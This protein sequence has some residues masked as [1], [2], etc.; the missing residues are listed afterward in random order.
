MTEIVLKEAK[1]K[2]TRE[3]KILATVAGVWFTVASLI[4]VLGAV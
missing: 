1:V 4:A 3:E 2:R